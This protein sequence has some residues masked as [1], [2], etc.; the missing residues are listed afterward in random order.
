MKKVSF[1][2]ISALILFSC[3]KFPKDTY[4]KVL[5]VPADFDWKSIEKQNVVVTHVSSVLNET[6]DT[7]ASFLPPGNYNLTVGKGTLL[8]IKTE[9]VSALTKATGTVKQRIFFPAKDKYATVMFEDL[10]PSKG[11]MDMNDIA[12]GLNIQIDMDN[13]ARV[14][15]IYFHI[16]PRAVGSSYRKIA[17]AVN[18]TNNL[19]TNPGLISYIYNTSNPELTKFFNVNYVNARAYTPELN[20]SKSEVIPLTGNFRSYFSDTTELFMNVRNIDPAIATTEFTVMADMLTKNYYYW[21]FS[22]FDAPAPGYIN[23]DLF[24]MFDVRSKEVHFK[25]QK[26]TERFNLQYMMYTL[27][28]TDFSTVDNWVWAIISD[29]SIRHPAEFVKIYNAYPNFKKWVESGGATNTTWYSPSVRDSLYTKKN[30][31]Y[32]N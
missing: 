22:L 8:N 17:L 30:Y 10:F 4:V 31:S 28:K 18:F 15:A 6:G 19:N 12:F 23:I 25:G 13:Q 1:I 26:Y 11:D 16:Q 32:I 27:P 7:I 14:L 24:A 21:D 2:L 20:N 3:V 5:D 29:K 9:Q